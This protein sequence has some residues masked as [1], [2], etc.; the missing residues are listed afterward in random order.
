MTVDSFP[1]HSACRG[2]IAQGWRSS[3]AGYWGKN[4]VRNFAELKALAA[5]VDQDRSTAQTLCAE[6]GGA[7]RELSRTCWRIASIAAVAVA[8]PAV[9]H[10][11]FAKAALEAGKHVFVEKPLALGL[12][13]GRRTVRRSPSAS[14][15]G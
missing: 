14:I 10:Y 11:R 8:T 13:R 9:L 15:A 2:M 4:I 1:R 5:V 3:A 12:E 6:H 7:A